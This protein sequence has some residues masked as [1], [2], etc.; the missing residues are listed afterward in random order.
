[1]GIVTVVGESDNLAIWMRPRKQKVIV[2]TL[3]TGGIDCCRNPRETVG[4]DS[5]K[6]DPGPSSPSR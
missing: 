2:V 5:L 3:F 1:M 4:C 6:F